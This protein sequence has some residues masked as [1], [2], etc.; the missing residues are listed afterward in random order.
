MSN[1]SERTKTIYVL[2]PDDLDRIDHLLG[3]LSVAVT[4]LFLSKRIKIPDTPDMLPAEEQLM[5]ERN[6]IGAEA[7]KSGA[8]DNDF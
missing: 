1:H 5:N 4:E 8:F 3:V 7:T 6:E 2:T